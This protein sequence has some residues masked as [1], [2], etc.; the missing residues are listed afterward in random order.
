MEK[1]LFDQ[2]V[3][4][5]E[6]TYDNIRKTPTDQGDDYTSG[7]LPKYVYFKNYYKMTAIHLSKQQALY[8]RPKAIYQ[9]NFT[10]NL[11]RAGKT[12][13]Y[14]NIE[15]VKETVLDFSWG[16]VKVL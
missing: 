4:N 8:A 13:M 10:T 2:L 16:T 11:D 12:A 1:N 3:K 9:I 14:F 15:K 6:R 7:C 5:D